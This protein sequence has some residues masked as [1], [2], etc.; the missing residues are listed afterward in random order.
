MEGEDTQYLEVKSVKPEFHREYLSSTLETVQ[1]FTSHR[2]WFCPTAPFFVAVTANFSKEK[3]GE[4][5]VCSFKLIWI[6]AKG[7]CEVPSQVVDL[8]HRVPVIQKLIHSFKVMPL[9]IL[10]T[11]FNSIL[12]PLQFPW[13]I[14][15]PV[16]VSMMGKESC[17]T[18]LEGNR[19]HCACQTD[20]NVRFNYTN[21]TT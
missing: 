15:L 4:R 9:G 19:Q 18:D 7:I 2:W 17:S 1:T 21:V 20:Q 14:L 6:S 3:L 10:I 16:K 5:R 11:S 12:V 13:K 8:L